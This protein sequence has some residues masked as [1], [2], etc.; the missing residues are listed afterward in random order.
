M[1]DMILSLQLLCASLLVLSIILMHIVKKNS[2]LVTAY[3]IQSVGLVVL[4]GIEVYKAAS[5]G[6]VV[7]TV[8]MFLIKVIFAPTLFGRLIKKSHQNLSASTYLNIP[9]TLIVLLALL[10]F[11]Q[12]EI[13][14]Q[15]SSLLPPM[16]SLKGALMGS[17]L[18]SIFLII[19]RKGALSQI[20]GVLSLE[21]SIFAF[22]IFLGVRQQSALELGILFDAFFWIMIASI[23]VTMIF[24]HFG[25]FDISKLNQLKK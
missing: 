4:L 3:V 5:L 7:V 8:V 11:S 14:S 1:T 25:S 20:I 18:L 24:K 15:V 10:V 6:L 22:G 19:N 21:N 12:S 9:M 17:I 2:T 23:F 16:Q 13:V